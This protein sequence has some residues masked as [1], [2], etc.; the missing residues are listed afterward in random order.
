M[1]L[2]AVLGSVSSKKQKADKSSVANLTKSKSASS[3]AIPTTAAG[4]AVNPDDLDTVQ[5]H[6]RQ[7]LSRYFHVEVTLNDRKKH[8]FKCFDVHTPEVIT[9]FSTSNA[10]CLLARVLTQFAV[11]DDLA[12]SVQVRLGLMVLFEILRHQRA[13][14]TDQFCQTNNFGKFQNEKRALESAGNKALPKGKPCGLMCFAE[15]L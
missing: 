11:P 5:E 1:L 9:V 8:T 10:Y 2:E 14:L 3:T 12:G 4:P 6:A 15:W 13:V 7:L